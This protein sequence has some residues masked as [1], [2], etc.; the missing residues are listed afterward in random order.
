M[1]S[2]S[3]SLRCP[4]CRKSIGGR[5]REGTGHRVSM[6]VVLIDDDGAVHG[7]CPHCRADITIADG[8]ELEKGLTPQRRPRLVLGLPAAVVDGVG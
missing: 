7:P 2:P 5:S 4:C 8:A 6:R 3:P 1:P